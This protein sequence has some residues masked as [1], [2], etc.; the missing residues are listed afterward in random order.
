MAS[1]FKR[2]TIEPTSTFWYDIPWFGISDHSFY[3]ENIVLYKNKSY[4]S[5]KQFKQC[6]YGASDSSR[7]CL[8]NS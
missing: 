6:N 3:V 7:K 2:G 8:S 1:V 4:I 5:I